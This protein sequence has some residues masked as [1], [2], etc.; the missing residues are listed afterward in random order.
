MSTT[1][2]FRSPHVKE[3]AV[4]RFHDELRATAKALGESAKA[5]KKLRSES[6]RQQALHRK[7]EKAHQVAK[8]DTQKSGN[9]WQMIPAKPRL[10]KREVRCYFL[11]FVPTIRE[12]RDFYREM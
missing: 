6:R 1:D 3:E 2:R 11:V 7:A 10:F 9:L 12:I 8:W 5:G 4:N